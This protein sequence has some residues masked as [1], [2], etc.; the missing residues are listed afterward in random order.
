ME[1]TGKLTIN[2]IIKAMDDL[3]KSASISRKRPLVW[4][5]VVGAGNIRYQYKLFKERPGGYDYFY[6]PN[7]GFFDRQ[8]NRYDT[9]PK[10]DKDAE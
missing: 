4:F 5:P 6:W 9:I 1:N 7:K 10:K 2:D 8:G 3:E